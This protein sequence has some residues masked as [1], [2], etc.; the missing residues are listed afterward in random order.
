MKRV[1]LIAV[2]ACGRDPSPQHDRVRADDLA[3]GPS[4]PDVGRVAD[5]LRGVIATDA[6]ARRREVASWKLDEPTFR[7]SV[8]PTYAPLY[9][10]YAHAFDAAAPALADALHAGA[11]TAR[12]HY[13]GDRK[14]TPNE[15]RLRWAL[16]VEYPTVVAELDGKPIDTVFVPFGRRWGALIGLDDVVRA[17]VG[18]RDPTCAARIDRAGVPGPCNDIGW[19]IVDGALRDDAE[20]FAHACRIAETLCVGK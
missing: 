12:G 18:R 6:D 17:R 1:L 3:S 8:L 16:P 5:Y 11:I 7:R 13:A 4:R 9:D 2:L 14:L 20:A 10:D 19:Q 15:A